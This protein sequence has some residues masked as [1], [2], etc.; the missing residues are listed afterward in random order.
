MEKYAQSTSL[1]QC[2]VEVFSLGWGHLYVISC[3]DLL[4]QRLLYFAMYNA[5]PHFCVH[6]TRDYYTHGM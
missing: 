2:K 1:G 3:L 4:E 5:H 6:Y